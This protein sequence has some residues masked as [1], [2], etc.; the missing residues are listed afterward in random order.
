METLPSPYGPPL[1][2]AVL[3]S[4]PE[5]FQVEEIPVCMPDGAGE[6]VWLK[7]CKR[8][9]NTDWVARQLARFAGVRPRDVSFAGLKDRHA[10]TEQWFSVHLP[11]R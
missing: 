5:D 9:Q 10:V 6:H 3:R 4:R 2:Q 8:G 11:G 7:I 1:G